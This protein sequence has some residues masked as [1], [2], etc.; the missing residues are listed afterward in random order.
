MN[1]MVR[2]SSL[3]ACLL[4]AAAGC[5]SDPSEEGD[6]S[7]SATEASTASGDESA[8]DTGP[9]GSCP[10]EGMFVACAE[11]GVAYCDDIDGEIQWGSCLSNVACEVGETIVGC[12]SCTLEEGVPTVIGSPTC[13]CEAPAAAACEQTE[14][15]QRWD[16]TCGLCESFTSG[17]CFSYDLGCGNPWLGCSNDAPTPCDR[18]WAQE[19]E[20]SMLGAFEDEAAATC[21]LTSLRDD[22]PGS[23]Q[24]LWGYMDDGGW[25]VLWVH[26]MGDGTAIVEWYYDCP[27]CFGFGSIGRSGTMSLQPDE[28]FDDCLAAPTPESLIECT[29]GLIEYQPSN[30]PP[31]GYVPP[32]VTGDCVSLDAAC[33]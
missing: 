8:D 9:S 13:E 6:G 33:P 31:E 29:V 16:Y 5:P 32:F 25:V 23:Y 15:M 4:L 1:R 24:I 2:R 10:L 20:S 17:D 12:Q 28:W 19:S 7:E 26:A 3:L 18:V 21:V 11:G 27:G 14:C 30:P 22:V